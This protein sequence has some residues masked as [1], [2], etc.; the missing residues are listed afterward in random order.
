LKTLCP[1]KRE[2]LIIPIL[3]PLVLGFAVAWVWAGFA[4]EPGEAA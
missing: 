2:S 1:S 4:R 3:I